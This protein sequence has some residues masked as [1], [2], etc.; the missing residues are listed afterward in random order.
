LAPTAAPD[1]DEVRR[2]RSGGVDD[3]RSRLAAMAERF[4]REAVPRPPH[5][6]GY[7]V[8]PERIEFWQSREHR[9]HDRQC[10][11]RGAGGWTMRLL[12]P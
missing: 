7:R 5:W 11:E 3:R 1:D 2:L 10:Y 9:L 4:A 6:R 8:T 12:N